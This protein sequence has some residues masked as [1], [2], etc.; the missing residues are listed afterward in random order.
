MH[1]INYSFYLHKKK[2]LLL[3]GPPQHSPSKVYY[4]DILFDQMAYSLFDQMLYLYL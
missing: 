4:M 3:L 1:A 2:K